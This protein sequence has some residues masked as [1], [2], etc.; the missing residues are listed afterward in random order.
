[1]TLGYMI[2]VF[3]LGKT[4]RVLEFKKVGLPYLESYDCDDC[5]GRI[6]V[7]WGGIMSGDGRKTVRAHCRR[8]GQP[9]VV[10]GVP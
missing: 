2:F 3:L 1:M 5:G 4:P 6:S 8:C 9:H 7:D 10:T